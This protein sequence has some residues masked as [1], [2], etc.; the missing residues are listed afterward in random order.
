MDSQLFL[1]VNLVIGVIFFVWFLSGRTRQEK[2]T[3]L[4]L[5]KGSFAPADP[6]LSS[7]P[8][9]LQNLES[10]QAA[11]PQ[12]RNHA[13]SQ[14]A[15]GK[16][17][18]IHIDSHAENHSG[19]HAPLPIKDRQLNILFLYNGHDWDAY[20]VLGL[21][22]GAGLHLVTERYQ[23]LQKTSDSG[24]SQFYEAAYQAILKKI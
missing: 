18:Q 7:A 12:P 14:D 23:Q 11:T 5:K 8:S 1:Y 17:A 3:P 16:A 2:A 22:A 9:P 24:Q 15:A 10:R 13:A 4:N 20:Q 6:S 21:P 19:S